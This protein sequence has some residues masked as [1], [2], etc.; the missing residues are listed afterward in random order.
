MPC[1][2]THIFKMMQQEETVCK[3]CKG[4]IT[5]MSGTNTCKECLMTPPLTLRLERLEEKMENGLISEGEYITECNNL[6]DWKKIEDLAERI[7]SFELQGD[8]SDEEPDDTLHIPDWQEV[9][10]MNIDGVVD[11]IINR[12]EYTREE[13]IEFYDEWKEC[14]GQTQTWSHCFVLERDMNETGEACH[15]IS[16]EIYDRNTRGPVLRL[17]CVMDDN[18]GESDVQW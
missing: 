12:E 6:R 17:L 2:K 10:R 8:E 11:Y 16:G 4:Y 15:R 14:Y 18:L 9:R 3:G 1:H 7:D 13:V 5:N